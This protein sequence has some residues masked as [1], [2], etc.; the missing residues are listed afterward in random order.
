MLFRP[1]RFPETV[2]LWPNFTVFGAAESDSASAC[3][4]GLSTGFPGGFFG[5]LSGG[6]SGGL[7]AVAAGTEAQADQDGGGDEDSVHLTR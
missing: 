5:G 4:G 7:W 1:V 2:T 6:L 3:F